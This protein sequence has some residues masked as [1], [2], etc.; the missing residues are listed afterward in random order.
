MFARFSR[1]EDFTSFSVLLLMLD[2]SWNQKVTWSWKACSLSVSD[3]AY[4]KPTGARNINYPCT[5]CKL[6]VGSSRGL[7]IL[8]M[9]ILLD[10]L[11]RKRVGI[12]ISH[13][14]LFRPPAL[15]CSDFCP[16]NMLSSLS[17][18]LHCVHAASPSGMP[19]FILPSRCRLQK[20]P[21]KDSV[22]FA[23]SCIVRCAPAASLTANA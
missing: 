21:G 4:L 17:L 16:W 12:C 3:L 6:F 19:Y 14:A 15:V 18:G 2:S 5:W 9:T 23:H 7:K 22:A 13:P 20:F 8:A 1:S 10:L 11:S